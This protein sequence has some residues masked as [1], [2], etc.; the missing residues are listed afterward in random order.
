[1]VEQPIAVIGAGNGGLALA[2]TLSLKGGR[3]SICD[4]VPSIIN[5]LR[6]VG[7]VFQIRNGVKSF[8]P[9]QAISCEYSQALS[10][11]M[12]VLVVTPASAHASVAKSI[13]PHLLP[14]AT[15]VLNPGRTGGAME[16]HAIFES[17]CPEKDITVAETQS[18]LYACRKTGP[19]EVTIKAEKKI[20]NIAALPH[21]RVA[22]VVSLLQPY[23]SVF[24]PVGS[25]FETSLANIGAMFH[26]AP[27]LFNAG[28]IE[29]THGSFEYYLQGI[30]PSVA[31]VV[32]QMDKERVRVARAFGLGLPSALKWLSLTYGVEADSLYEAIQANAAYK[33]IKAPDS[34]NV[35]Y[36][37]E[38]VP[39]GLVPI[40]E[41][42]RLAGCETPVIDRVIDMVSA[43][44]QVNFR[45]KG[46]NLHSLG[47][48]GATVAECL[49]M[50]SK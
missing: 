29:S 36:L 9:F 26:P 34:I 50:A 44:L 39:T 2:S 48:G 25:V 28:W 35:R 6:E 41:L 3:V 11:A 24:T 17:L 38:D 49:A 18:L 21:G 30:S 37:T 12:L 19:A 5:P 16:V 4:L 45:E 47:L 46:R 7:G 8:A 32:E 14:G 40:S 22:D 31:N 10:G 23:F 15:V 1:M 20:L 13:A 42:G 43:L 27:T 33:G